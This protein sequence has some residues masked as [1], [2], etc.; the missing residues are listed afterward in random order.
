[1][2]ILKDC[3]RF[4]LLCLLIMAK[5]VPY[6]KKSEHVWGLISSEECNVGLVVHY[7][8]NVAPFQHWNIVEK[9][10]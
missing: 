7:N 10:L 2:N 4:C 5:N 3:G 6:T 9:C 8:L 1:M